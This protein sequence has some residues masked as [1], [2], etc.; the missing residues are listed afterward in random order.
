MLTLC[1]IKGVSCVNIE[2]VLNIEV[3]DVLAKQLVSS[4]KLIKHMLIA[5]QRGQI[6]THLVELNS[7][8]DDISR[9]QQQ[10]ISATK[11]ERI[12]IDD[13]IV[14]RLPTAVQVHGKFINFRV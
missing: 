3:K 8:K 9:M 6:T 11:V 4:L 12:D 5:N 10:V 13:Q 2:N 1:K 14:E 7:T